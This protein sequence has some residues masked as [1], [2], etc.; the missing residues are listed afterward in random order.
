MISGEEVACEFVKLA[1]RR[2]LS[3][4]EKQGDK[5]FPFFFSEEQAQRALDFFRILRHTSGSLAGK[6]F[7]IQDNQ[8]FKTAMIF[9]WRRK[10]N[11]CR[12]FT[13]VYIEEARKG[14]KSQWAAGV[15]IYCALCE[16]EEGAEV[17]TAATTRDQ[18][19]NVFRAAK[20][21]CNKLRQDSAAIRRAVDVTTHSIVLKGNG[22]FIQKVSADADTL[23]GLNP[24]CAVIDEYHAHKNDKVKG[25][26]QTGMG[27]WPAPLLLIITTAGFNKDYPCYSVE[28]SNAVA[29]LRGER[30]QDNLFA[31]IFTLDEGDDWQDERVWRKSNPNL[32]ST[33]TV[34]Y[35][36]DQVKDALNKGASTRVQVLT[37]NFNVWMDAP[38]VWI[39]SED[40][41]ACM[42]KLD[43]RD[44]AGR[45]CYMGI[46]LAATNDVTALCA[47]FPPQDEMPAHSFSFF[48]LPE[49]TIEKRRN[50]AGYADWVENGYIIVTPGN[51]ADYA[52]MRA[53]IIELSEFL[54]VGVISYDRWNA[55][56]L[57]TELTDNGFEMQLCIQ[58]FSNLSEPSKKIEKMVLSGGIV[59]DE[60][61]VLS[62]MF[63]NVVMDRDSNDNIKP[64]KKKSREKIDGVTAKAMAVFGWLT[65]TNNSSVSSY[66]LEGGA[67]LLIV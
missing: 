18:A 9:G 22:S 2:H 29:V 34:Q 30:E 66:L 53:K 60:N 7:N 63:G 62:W 10:E 40:V 20:A 1:V 67:S 47:F 35:L 28:R 31:I 16:G 13:Q 24:Y 43:I 51:V 27:T 33:P 36:R 11:M 3:D 42:Q 61:P 25:V 17:Y 38:E 49:D 54:D 5:D 15:E 12:R 14:G 23:D 52:Y 64:N 59:M 41:A 44:F 45:K 19:D 46:D 58:N 37:K 8:A 48:F 4:I 65:N 57:V 56:Q 50:D 21:M 26:M 55:Y 6:H 39:P 32:G